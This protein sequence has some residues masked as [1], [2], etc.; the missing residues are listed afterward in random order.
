MNSQQMCIGVLESKQGRPEIEVW[1]KI[2]KNLKWR[3][4]TFETLRFSNLE[5]PRL[6]SYQKRCI[7]IKVYIFVWI[8]IKVEISASLP[9]NLTEYEIV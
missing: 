9:L 3:K 2:L 1:S 7:V 8:Q 5:H 6:N 4:R